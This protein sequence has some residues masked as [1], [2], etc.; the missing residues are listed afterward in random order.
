MIFAL[1]V[2]PYLR[3]HFVVWALAETIVMRMKNMDIITKN[4]P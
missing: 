3:I 2:D 1:D 4:V